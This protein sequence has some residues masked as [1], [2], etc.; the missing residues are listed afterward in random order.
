MGTANTNKDT[1][2]LPK[3]DEI[4]SS[5][6]ERDGIVA[7][8]LPLSQL[9]DFPDHPFKV[10]EDDEMK[11]LIESIKGLGQLT[12]AIVRKL[13]NGRYEIISGHRR[14]Y[15]NEKIGN[16]TMPC[17]IIDV[18]KE[19]AT[20]LMV[21]SNIYRNNI[22]TSE[23]AFAY[24]MRFNAIKDMKKKMLEN[25][26]WAS[27]RNIPEYLKGKSKDLAANEIGISRTQGTRYIRFTMLN[28]YLLDKLDDGKLSQ[29][30]AFNLSFLDEESM[31]TVCEEIKK[32]A[33]VP[34]SAV[35][36]QLKSM[37]DDKTLDADKIH[38]AMNPEKEEKEEKFSLKGADI[39]KHIPK[40]IK[41]VEDLEKFLTEAIDLYVALLKS[42]SFEDYT[43]K[44][45]KA[46]DHAKRQD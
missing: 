12:P 8:E 7:V 40:D 3:Y 9:D 30:S 16:T 35:S 23:K 37:S 43:G 6:A 33:K 4:F 10:Q 38:L 5:Q 34:D 21:E 15:A 45:K 1:F 18:S 41:T 25:A 11:S 26:D 32:G 29:D 27:K 19:E 42:K 14:K 20:V 28:R 36:M 31:E 17:Q 13:E 24:K 44:A 46:W 22:T 2:D 39:K